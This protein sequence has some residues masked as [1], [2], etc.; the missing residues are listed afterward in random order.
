MTRHALKALLLLSL[1]PVCAP[2]APAQDDGGGRDD[3]DAGTRIVRGEL[4]EIRDKS[5]VLL[6]VSRS[7][8]IDIRGTL[9]GVLEEVFSDSPR[10]APR[11]QYAYD[12]IAK[13]FE[14]YA[15]DRGA[16]TTVETMEEAEFVIVYKAIAEHRSFA[17]DEPFVYGE[18]FVFLKS[19]P[20]RPQ[21]VLLW[22]TKDDHANPSD[23]AGDFLKAL[24]A[25]RGER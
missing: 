6:I 11:H 18:M 8:L 24:K 13:K 15:R 19:G 23:A 10:P 20:E 16:L 1:L 12:Q 17:P 2:R 14:R 22:R 25:V 9:H 5:R 7:L 3:D 21:P 4:S